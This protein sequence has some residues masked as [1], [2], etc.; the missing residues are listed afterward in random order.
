MQKAA[1]LIS[2][3]HAAASSGEYDSY[4]G[5]TNWGC[6]TQ[7]KYQKYVPDSFIIL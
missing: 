1:R 4:C 7:H 6:N 5:S 3:A 2:G